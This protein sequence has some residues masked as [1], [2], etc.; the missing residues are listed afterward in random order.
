MEFTR[1]TTIGLF[2]GIIALGTASLIAAPM[3]TTSTVLMMV[4]PSMVVFGLVMFAI[5]LK[6]GEYQATH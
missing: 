3:M 4:L 2:V 1:T 5:G 6:H